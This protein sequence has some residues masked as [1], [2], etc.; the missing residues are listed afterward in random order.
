MA[1]A[2][3]Q[4]ADRL[5]APTQQFARA[6]RPVQ[7]AA[8]QARAHRRHR[9]VEY[10]EQGMFGA[11][12]GMGVQLQVASGRRV[13]RDGFAGVF[14]GHAGEVRQR[15]FLGFLDVAE[16][17]AGCRD[18]QIHAVDAEAAEVAGAEEAI[19]FALRR[20]AV[21]VPGWTLAQAG[22]AADQL[23]PRHV[24][25]DQCFGG[26][27]TGQFGGQCFGMG[28]LAEQEA[29]TG[30]IDPG[31][32]VGTVRACGDRQEQIVAT[33][34]QQRGI[35]HRARGDDAHH[36]AFD[37]A[38]G[39]RRVADLLADRHRFAEPHQPREI[40]FR[41]VIRHAGHRNRCP[42]RL[43]TLGQRDV[44]QPRGLACIVEEQLVEIAHAEEQQHLRM[45]GLGRQVLAHERGMFGG[46]FGLHGPW[47]HRGLPWIGRDSHD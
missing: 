25:V 7:P 39:Q 47:V 35:G 23:R 22:Q 1:S 6:Q 32:A 17:A 9:L 40:I 12:A 33:F 31:Q 24:F 4:G 43:P 8:Q 28:H 10:A 13:Q 16:Q 26:L 37:D 29:S 15:A 27:Q 14:H 30:Q 46:F 41:R 38:L 20:I 3:D 19:E 2:V 42:G 5:M 44:E 34:L 36:L 45:F 21:V 11:T 18:R